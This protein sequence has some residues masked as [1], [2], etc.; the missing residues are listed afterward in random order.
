AAFALVDAGVRELVVANRT[1]ARARSLV[2]A[3]GAPALACAWE[4]LRR[5]PGFDLVVNATS[6]G[7]AGHPFAWPLADLVP[8]ACYDLSYGAVAR[9]FLAAARNY[10][11]R[12]T[13]D[14]LGMLVEQAA[15]SFEC[16]HGVHPDTA[17]VHAELRALL[18]ERG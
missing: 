11:M 4:A 12:S 15:E 1:A 17:P 5:E 6:A 8:T 18:D 7:H 14:G 9:P 3:L 16:W 13:H 10:G 2:D